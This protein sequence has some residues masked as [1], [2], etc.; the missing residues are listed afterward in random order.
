[1]LWVWLLRLPGLCCF[2]REGK[3]GERD[4]TMMRFA[5]VICRTMGSL[6]KNKEMYE[7]RMESDES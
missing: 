1:M 4:L 3:S 7:L 2:C 6:S 5:T